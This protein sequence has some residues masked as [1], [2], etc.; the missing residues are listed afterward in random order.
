MNPADAMRD[1]IVKGSRNGEL[2]FQGAK[3]NDLNTIQA[4]LSSFRQ[5]EFYD[6]KLLS[7][8]IV[9][10]FQADSSNINGIVTVLEQLTYLG[11]YDSKMVLSGVSSVLSGGA[12]LSV[13]SQD[14]LRVLGVLCRQRIRI[15]KLVC[16]IE[17]EHYHN[18]SPSDQILFLKNAASLRIDVDRNL[19]FKLQ[20]PAK[21]NDCTNLVLACIFDAGTRGM[22]AR[23]GELIRQT[24]GA[25]PQNL[26]RES[27]S[28]QTHR[29]LV[30]ISYALRFLYDESI[31]SNL[32]EDVKQFLISSCLEPC[33]P[34]HI[35]RKNPPN[36]KLVQSVSDTLF[37]MS[38]K[39]STHV[40]NGPFMIDVL[41]EG[42]QIVWEC[43]S[44][45]KFYEAD[46]VPIK[47]AYY[48]L[49]ELVMRA[50]GYRILQIPFW[51]WARITNRRKRIEFCRM[52]RHLALNDM[53]ENR[54]GNQ[55]TMSTDPDCFKAR[56]WV[57]GSST[58]LDYHGEYVLNKEQPKRSWSWN[59]HCNIPVRIA[60]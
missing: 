13:H 17:R 43:N 54:F 32:G 48:H 52:N 31:Y 21:I 40:V 27:C 49:Q 10:Q 8:L 2:P 57:E 22:T 15:P 39:H 53:R 41:E 7:D 50:M 36:T 37:K 3:M 6:F 23:L 56:E 42:R 46:R 18:L 9:G 14:A 25:C 24:L 19:F 20:V 44:K 51:H 29:D 58:E 45:I 33:E 1:L 11:N 30:L 34:L 16:L 4:L 38:V 12:F 26:K 47:T 55:E 35:G 60:L 59:G 28:K 5:T